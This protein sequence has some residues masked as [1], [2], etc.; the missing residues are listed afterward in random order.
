MA[1]EYLYGKLPMFDGKEFNRFVREAP[2]HVVKHNC[3]PTK[4]L[5][6]RINTLTA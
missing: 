1:S 6:K 3:I 5:E 4:R 2:E